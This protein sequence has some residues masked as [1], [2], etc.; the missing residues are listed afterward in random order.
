MRNYESSPTLIGT[1]VCENSPDQMAGSYNDDGGNC[2]SESCT[3]CATCPF[4]INGDGDVG[5]ADLT[6]ILNAWGCTGPSCL[7]DMNG[8]DLVDGADLTVILNRWGECSE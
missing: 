7:G 8:D 6:I 1:T 4:D 5:G 3:T 2:V